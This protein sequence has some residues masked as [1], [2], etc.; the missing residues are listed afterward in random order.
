MT[1]N[2]ISFDTWTPMSFKR[3]MGDRSIPGQSWTAPTW[4]G[5]HARRLT[6]YLVLQSYVDN[7]ARHFLQLTDESDRAEHREYGDAALLRNQILSALLGEEQRIV[8][9]GATA[10]GDDDELTPEAESAAQL[11]SWLESWAAS[12]R[13]LIKVMECERSSVTLG[14]GVYALGWSA[15]LGRPRLRVYDPGFYFPVLDDGSDDD[16]P[17][18]V[19]IAWEL[20]PDERGKRRI[21]R[22]TWELVDTGVERTYPWSDSPTTQACLFTD[23]VWSLDGEKARVDDLSESAAQYMVNDDGLEVRGLDLGLDF[24]PVVHIPNTVSVQEHYGRSSLSYV[25]QVLDDLANGDTDLQAASA[26]TGTPPISLSG[27]TLGSD[28]LSYS[29]GTVFGIGDGR[30]DVLDTSKSLD[31]LLKYVD[32]LL[33]R[34]SVNSRVPESVLGR[35]DPSEVP[36]GIALK[37]SFGPMSSM[38]REMRLA[39]EDKYSLL[40]KFA[41]RIAVAGGADGVPDEYYP[42]RMEFGNYLPSDQ[43][44]IVELVVRLLEAKA[45]SL[46]TAVAMLVDAGVPIEA[47]ADE[48]DRIQ[49]RD[50]EGANSLLDAT[51]DQA[52]TFEYLG[53]SAP[54]QP[55]APQPPI[56]EE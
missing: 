22:M 54:D 4:V 6:A 40:L 46:E 25:L 53:R 52:A 36:S 17:T 47:I 41:W 15:T 44:S 12:E 3:A 11:Q 1:I 23:A 5:E 18:R 38:I 27:A 51:G 42:A 48:V 20:D 43:S 31:A 9:G 30:M 55:A 14:D 50:F 39:R 19:H 16:Y 2:E 28:Q 21:R 7:A 35:L 13:M 10:T 26:T 49:A 37:L 32:A 24:I 8:V 34:L 45:V 29:P 56:E 33:K